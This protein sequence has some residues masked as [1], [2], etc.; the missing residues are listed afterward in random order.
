MQNVYLFISYEIFK[1]FKVYRLPHSWNHL[2]HA[3]SKDQ[4]HNLRTTYL[5]ITSFPVINPL[6]DFTETR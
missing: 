1:Y 2:M 6:S 4:I 5:Q 3:R